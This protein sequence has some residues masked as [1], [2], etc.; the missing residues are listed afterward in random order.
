[1]RMWGAEAEVLLQSLRCRQ[2]PPQAHV[3]AAVP[4]RRDSEEMVTYISENTTVTSADEEKLLLLNKNTELRRI[5]KE[6]M[7]LNQEWDSVYHSTTR[8][9]EHRLGVLQEKASALAAQAQK[10][11]LKLEHEQSTREYYEQALFQELKRSQALQDYVTQLEGRRPPGQEVQECRALLP[12]PWEECP[13]PAGQP[14]LA[15]RSVMGNAVNQRKEVFLNK[16][17]SS[18]DSAAQEHPFCAAQQSLASTEKEVTDLRVQLEALRCQTEIY[19]ADYR[20]EQKDRQRIKAENMKLRRKEE[21]MRQQMTLLEEQLKI[22]ED[23]FWRERSDKQMLQ[24]LLKTKTPR[25]KEPTLVHRCNSPEKAPAPTAALPR[26]GSCPCSC[27]GKE[28]SP[29]QGK[30]N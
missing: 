10:L 11:S 4:E 21:E 6:L 15:E 26:R 24:R 8:G 23:D 7:K 13:A 14:N 19:K 27:H 3:R 17:G 1:M 18:K 25:A 2:D 22:F 29:C 5:N 9:L 12:L 20:M 16:A 30:H 28:H